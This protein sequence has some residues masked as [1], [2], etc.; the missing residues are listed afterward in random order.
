[1]SVFDDMQK[2][3]AD[4]LGAL[5]ARDELAKRKA[6]REGEEIAKRAFAEARSILNEPS[7]EYRQ[8]VKDGIE[9]ACG[10]FVDGWRKLNEMG[11]KMTLI[12][13]P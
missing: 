1:M 7:L 10:S 6:E 3:S 5:C 4:P 8:G 12:K 9:I 11:L 2:E 13:K